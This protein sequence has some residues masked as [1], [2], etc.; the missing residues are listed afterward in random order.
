MVDN[1]YDQFVKYHGDAQALVAVFTGKSVHLATVCV[2]G[3][4][5]DVEKLSGLYSTVRTR[6]ESM[7]SF[8][9]SVIP[10]LWKYL[11]MHLPDDV[12]DRPAHMISSGTPFYSGLASGYVHSYL[13]ASGGVLIADTKDP[14]SVERARL[15]PFYPERVGKITLARGSN[16]DERCYSY[17]EVG[18]YEWNGT[19]YACEAG[20]LTR[21]SGSLQG[22]G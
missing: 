15:V 14:G 2:G 11:S 18:Y 20:P 8:L 5:G 9:E 19:K 7:R 12:G 10:T 1:L 3:Y 22:R 16:L 13:A 17:S 21:F 6:P 4:A